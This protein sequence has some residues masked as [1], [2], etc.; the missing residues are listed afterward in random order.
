MIEPKGTLYIVSAPSGCGK[1][2]LV[3]ALIAS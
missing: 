1:T 3:D 2:S